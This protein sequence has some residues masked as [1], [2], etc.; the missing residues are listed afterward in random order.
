[1]DTV[2]PDGDYVDLAGA[3]VHRHGYLERFLFRA[4]QMNMPVSMLSGGEQSRLLLARL[5][6]RPAQVLVLDEPTNDL[7]LPTLR[8][9]EDAL[10]SFSGAVLLVSHDRYFVGQVATQLL[11]FHT[12]PDEL[13][14]VSAFADLA[15]WEA[16]RATQ[17]APRRRSGAAAETSR[18]PSKKLSYKDQREWDTIESRITAAEAHLAALAA[19]LEHPDTVSDAP[20]LIAL[21]EEMAA[22]R[23]AIDD[24]YTRWAELEALRSG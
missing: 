10:A 22:A 1:V 18:A 5:M 17:A 19:Q 4:E 8:V 6:L 9:L 11:A 15:Q 3:R 12:H 14:R 7:D 13:G 16:W 2:C 21:Q 20:R 23:A 24:I